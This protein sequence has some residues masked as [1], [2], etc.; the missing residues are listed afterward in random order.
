MEIFPVNTLH[1]QHRVSHRNAFS[2]C[3]TALRIW[4]RPPNSQA[5]P[6]LDGGRV[7]TR[8]PVAL[9]NTSLTPIALLDRLHIWVYL[10][11]SA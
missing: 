2:S 5:D 3:P 6:G 7:R 9:R 1:R 4:N 10:E 11:E 8:K